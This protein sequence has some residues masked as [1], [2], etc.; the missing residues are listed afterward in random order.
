MK[1]IKLILC[2]ASVAHVGFASTVLDSGFDRENVAPGNVMPVK[3]ERPKGGDVSEHK[4]KSGVVRKALLDEA[5]IISDKVVRNRKPNSKYVQEEYQRV[6]KASSEIRAERRLVKIKRPKT[7][8]T[9]TKAD[10]RKSPDHVTDIFSDD[11]GNTSPED[12]SRT[13]SSADVVDA[14]LDELNASFGSNDFGFNFAN[15][16]DQSPTLVSKDAVTVVPATPTQ[17]DW[18]ETFRVLGQDVTPFEFDDSHE[19]WVF[20]PYNPGT[21]TG[22][23][24]DGPVSP[25]VLG[26]VNDGV[27]GMMD[28]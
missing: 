20:L 16:E 4:S 15:D 9:S 21:Y 8:D 12:R 14:S 27:M 19:G 11:S 18:D 24:F 22:S 13:V 17:G 1:I 23:F 28:N 7:K 26:D 5:N 25:F 2:V 6:R 10:L 3:R